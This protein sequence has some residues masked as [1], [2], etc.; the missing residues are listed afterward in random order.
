LIWII[1]S[2]ENITVFT[3]K[4]L[5]ILPFTPFKVMVQKIVGGFDKN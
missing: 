3:F 4:S 5:F 2:E 1:S